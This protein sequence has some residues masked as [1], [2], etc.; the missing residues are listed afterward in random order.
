MLVLVGYGKW[1]MTL[2]LGGNIL[3]DMPPTQRNYMRQVRQR[4]PNII[5]IYAR[6][7]VP[8]EINYV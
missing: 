7:T 2:A 6:R 1:T 5:A 3:P 4:N 8:N